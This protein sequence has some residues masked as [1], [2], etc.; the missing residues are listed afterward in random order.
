MRRRGGVGAVGVLALALC[1]A[2]GC[3]S[4]AAP[5]AVR[6]A[7]NAEA[8]DELALFDGVHVALAEPDDGIVRVVG[9]KMSC[10]GTLIAD[11]RVLTA[12]HCIVE[13]GGF[14][15]SFCRSSSIRRSCRSS[16][17][18]AISPGAPSACGRSWLRRAAK[19]ADGATSRC[20]CS[21]ESSSAFRR[22]P[23]SS[24]SRRRA[25]RCSAPWGS[26]GARRHPPASI[27]AAATGGRSTRS[28]PARST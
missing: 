21:S 17:A 22:M 18:A 13:R 2:M 3:A 4:R 15:A 20:S 24:K 11:D 14:A 1:G 23:F 27:G 28:T 16:S 9:P 7:A 6:A 19:R 26:G 8:A 5:I 10:T 25:A 12:H